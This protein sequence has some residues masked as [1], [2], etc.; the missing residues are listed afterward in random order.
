MSGYFADCQFI[1]MAMVPKHAQEFPVLE[2]LDLELANLLL[3]MYALKHLRGNAILDP[4]HENVSYT[5]Q[6]LAIAL[7]NNKTALSGAFLKV[8]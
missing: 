3:S 1:R 4:S 2:H 8:G 7:V 6:Q 5:A